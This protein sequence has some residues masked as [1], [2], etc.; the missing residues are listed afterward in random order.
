M[1]AA[2]GG[3][4]FFLVLFSY[5]FFIDGMTG[6]TVAIGSVI[7]LAVLMRVTAHTDWEGLFQR[8]QTASTSRPSAEAAPAFSQRA[9]ARRRGTGALA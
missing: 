3:Q 5:T 7:T 1:R 9:L 6:L 4:L 2:I 8:P